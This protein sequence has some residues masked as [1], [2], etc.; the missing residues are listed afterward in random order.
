MPSL[1]SETKAFVSAID[2]MLDTREIYKKVTDTPNEGFVTDIMLGAG[3]KRAVT[4][5]VY[6]NFEAES[7]FS[8]LVVS[9]VTSG[10]GTSIVI[11]VC[12]AATSGIARLDDMIATASTTQ[13][14]TAFVT[15]I[16]T[17]SGIDTITV[18][19]PSSA[20]LTISNNDKLSIYSVALGEAAGHRQNIR[21]SL[22]KRS[23]KLQIFGESSQITDVQN[24]STI[25]V[26][27]PGETGDVQGYLMYDHVQKVL[28]LK[29]E[30]N[31]QVWAGEMSLTS[32]SDTNGFLIDNYT[33][34]GGGNGP[35]QTTRGIDQYIAAY[36]V[37]TSPVATL[38]APILSD[39][40]NVLDGLIANRA[41]KDY[42]VCQS[43]KSKR[44]YD[45]LFKNLGSSGVNSVRVIINGNDLD[46]TVDKIAYGGFNLY[47]MPMPIFDHP[48]LLGT[49]AIAKNSYYVPY[50]TRVKTF[51]GGYEP[52]MCMCYF[53]NQ[54]PL[55][56]EII[57]ESETGAL[58]KRRPTGT[59][60]QWITSWITTQG[61]EILGPSFYARQQTVA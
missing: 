51:N 58:A 26:T 35:V 13:T 49:T 16:S 23:N 59:I 41:D 33:V 5:P 44:A 42:W 18:R 29:G 2:P 57:G 55:G 4:Q 50:D 7:V 39:I 19:S 17:S 34:S 36:G 30:L 21:F 40:D 38:G 61:L 52:S 43:K 8:Q 54:N 46:L 25:E 56:D 20:F 24:A 12:T 22:P 9:S 37:T 10:S 31:A 11:F 15:N 3:N 6:Y 47:L 60:Q 45:K 32:F 28:K 27:I 48:T 14:L 1:G 53:K